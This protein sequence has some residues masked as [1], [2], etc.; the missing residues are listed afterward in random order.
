MSDVIRTLGKNGIELTEYKGE[1]ALVATYEAANGTHYQQW[2]KPKI[3]K[4]S[5]SEK[6]RPI[7]VV[8]G[9]RKGALAVLHMIIK[10]LE[11]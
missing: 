6:D 7:K 5:Y 3:G 9:D 2:G 11:R 1:F 4:D 10:Q 8:L